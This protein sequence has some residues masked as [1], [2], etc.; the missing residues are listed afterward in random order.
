MSNPRYPSLYQVNTRVLLKSLGRT[1]GRRATL[2]D[3]PDSLLDRFAAQGFDWIWL[4]SVW[5][6][7]D[8]ARKISRSNPE[9]LHEFR[10][11]LPDLTDED[12][13]GSGFAITDYVAH[14]D[15][16]GDAAL[17]RLRERLSRRGLRLMLD[18]VPNHM[19]LGHP[20]AESHPEYFVPGNEL[21][22]ARAPQNYTWVRRSQG[23]L[24][25]AHGRDPYFPGWPDT[26]QLN[27]AE[28]ATQEAM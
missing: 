3:V 1:L 9:W 6:T 15:L 20:W 8:A 2:D 26:L 18:F 28:P 17:A 5:M 13:A 24:M 19:G 14:P 4:L 23:D 7:G 27:Y 21:E 25:F 10:Q 16:G 11:T 22:L 12:I